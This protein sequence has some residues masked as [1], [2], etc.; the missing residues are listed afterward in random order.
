MPRA[1]GIFPYAVGWQPWVS[2][3]W[4]S[5]LVPTLWASRH[6]SWSWSGPPLH[7][8]RNVCEKFPS[9]KWIL[10][11]SGCYSLFYYYY[12]KDLLH[13]NSLKYIWGYK[14]VPTTNLQHYHF[15]YLQHYHFMYLQHYHF[16]Y[17]QHY[18]FMYLQ[19]YHFMYL[20]HYYFMYLQHY[21]VFTTLSLHVFTTLSCIY[22]I[23]TS[24]IY[25]IITSCI[26]VGK[27]KTYWC[28]SGEK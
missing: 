28:F 26:R 2:V 15:M 4:N 25:N 13:R 27:R 12:L 23:I 3:F 22:N 16:M 11:A 10:N 8:R 9:S 6:S 17:L 1:K 5:T 19:H 20:Q 7:K 21:H 14:I 18:H 24:C